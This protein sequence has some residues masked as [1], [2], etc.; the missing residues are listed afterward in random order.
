MFAR[1]QPLVLRMLHKKQTD[2]ISM[3]S[4]LQPVIANIT[5]TQFEKF[6]LDKLNNDIVKFYINGLYMTLYY[7][8]NMKITI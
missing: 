1:R 2:R 4:S 7:W 3:S 8:L 6:I 5:M